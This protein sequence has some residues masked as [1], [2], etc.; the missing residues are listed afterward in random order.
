MWNN[1]KLLF[2]SLT[3]AV[4]YTTNA[5]LAIATAIHWFNSKIL[6]EA[7]IKSASKRHDITIHRDG[8]T[9]SESF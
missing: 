6:M 9:I 5:H 3:S 1:Q 8:Q 2:F 7:R 4:T